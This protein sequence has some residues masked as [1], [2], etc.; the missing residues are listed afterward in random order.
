ADSKFIAVQTSPTGQAGIGVNVGNVPGALP[1]PKIRMW[2]VATGKEMGQFP[3][4]LPSGGG[5]IAAS[6]DGRLI[7]TENSDQT[8]TL[9]EI[10][11]GRP[12]R[13]LGKADPGSG[14]VSLSIGV[15]LGPRHV[16]PRAANPATTIAFS[17]D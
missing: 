10:A 1:E 8:A 3:L 5:T 11:S 2:D 16:V 17:P 14:Q 9:W 7:A 12:R 6:R 15:G 13:R 4:A